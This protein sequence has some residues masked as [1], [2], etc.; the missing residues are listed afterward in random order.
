MEGRG[1]INSEMGVGWGGVG[2]NYFLLNPNVSLPS[3]FT[4]GWHSFSLKGT[5]WHV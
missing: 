4:L 3:L 2:E 5:M 1:K